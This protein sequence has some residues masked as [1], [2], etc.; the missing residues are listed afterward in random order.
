MIATEIFSCVLTH[1]NLVYIQSLHVSDTYRVQTQK[2]F[3]Q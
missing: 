1:P 2:T 3:K